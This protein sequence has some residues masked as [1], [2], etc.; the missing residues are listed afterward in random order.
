MRE[1][2]VLGDRFA[3]LRGR[4]HLGQ[5]LLDHVMRLRVHKLLQ[6]GVGLGDLRRPRRLLFRRFGDHGKGL[7][8]TLRVMTPM[9][10]ARTSSAAIC[11]HEGFESWPDTSWP[12]PAVRDILP[13]GFSLVGTIM[14]TKIDELV[15]RL[16]RITGEDA[17]TAL[18]RA[19]EERLA[20]VTQTGPVD[21]EG[22]LRRFFE[23]VSRMPIKDSRPIDE[24]DGY[25]PDGLPS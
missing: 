18:E 20:R 3:A 6:L 21:R 4:A 23:H 19:V 13:T 22:A 10:R 9:S 8:P 24:I 17:E 12:S 14:F 25:G 1:S 11:A 5:D 16:S 15:Q 2:L 7:C